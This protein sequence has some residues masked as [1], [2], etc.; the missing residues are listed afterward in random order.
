MPVEGAEGA[1]QKVGSFLPGSGVCLFLFLL[2]YQRATSGVVW[3]HPVV[4][5]FPWWVWG[6]PLHC[7]PPD[8]DTTGN[9]FREP[10]LLL[11]SHL[12]A[13]TC[14]YIGRIFSAQG[15][16]TNSSPGQPMKVHCYPLGDNH[17]FS[18]EVWTQ[19]LRTRLSLLNL[20]LP[21]ILSLTLEVLFRVFLMPLYLFPS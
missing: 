9:W 7:S 15:L 5:T 6:W 14:L 16:S 8:L 3:G 10:H 21:C 2:L 11:W 19:D 18:N 1:L 20:F 17:T 4:H 12:T 13:S